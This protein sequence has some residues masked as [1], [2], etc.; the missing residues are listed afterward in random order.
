MRLS[1]VLL[2]ALAAV[3]CVTD[4]EAQRRRRSTVQDEIKGQERRLSEAR[5]LE[6]RLLELRIRQ[7][8]GLPVRSGRYVDLSEEE[9]DRVRFGGREALESEEARV[10]DLSG[11][12]A[13]IESALDGNRAAAPAFESEMPPSTGLLGAGAGS[14]DLGA[15]LRRK[16]NRPILPDD[17]DPATAGAQENTPTT[18]G[19]AGVT[20]RLPV[21]VPLEVGAEGAD[22]IHGSLDAFAVGRALLRHAEALLSA[23][24]D[25]EGS[26]E[27]ERAQSYRQAAVA[28]LGKARSEL[29]PL[30]YVE[31]EGKLAKHLREDA[32]LR[33]MFLLAKCEELLGDFSTASGLYID[34][35]NR[36]RTET[37]AG[38]TY[39]RWGLAAD[40]AKRVLDFLL[41]HKNWDP[42]PKIEAIEWR[43]Q[44]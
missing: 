1:A 12:L 13:A 42:L 44:G 34:I 8:L 15:A 39:G 28:E 5:N 14:I 17:S 18:S 25:A 20:A 43:K 4:V 36:D 24:K 33:A 29:E 6:Q 3:T 22:L 35:M 21:G 38:V 32:S 9:R 11:Q 41:E 10:R 30:V 7:D 27:T 37:E 23:A 19:E 40:S 26:E 16:S 31:D 2:T